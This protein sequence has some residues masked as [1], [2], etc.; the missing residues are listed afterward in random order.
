MGRSR[1]KKWSKFIEEAGV[2]VRIYERAGSKAIYREVRLPDG[3]KD[4]KSL[5]T[6][7]RTE[8]EALARELCRELATAHLTGTDLRRPT[9]GQGFSAYF[10]MRTGKAATLS[11]DRLRYAETCRDLFEAAWGPDL[12]IANLSQTH[13]DRYSASR[14][15][16]ELSPLGKG[17]G[18]GDR[19]PMEVRDG[20]LDNNFRWL[21]AVFN[22]ARRHKVNGKRLLSEN[23]LHDV[24]WPREKNPRRPVASH[25]RFL[26]TMQHV[27]AVDSEG[28]LRAILALARWTGRRESAICGLLASDILLSPERIR[29]ALAA[30]G[31][32]EGLGQHMP[33][34]A[35]RWPATTDKQGILH[36]TPISGAVRNELDRYLK[37]N[38]RMGDTPLFPALGDPEAPIR[39][40]TAS[41]LLLKAEK[42]AE[43]PKLRGGTFHPY[44]R[45]WATERKHLPDADVAAAGGWTDTRALKLSY[46][47]ADAATVLKVV[48]HEVA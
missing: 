12:E 45:L 31:M 2:R 43:L 24:T 42:L 16:G 27:D 29:D 38:P 13:I 18:Q 20:T 19:P 25:Q 41:S 10:D 33:H 8:A 40:D 6:R 44:R 35:I 5:K 34:G 3:S 47:H 14:R 11:E 9:L 28:R 46:Q 39:R 26:A 36:I 1:R 7:D 30:A 32:D 22:W 48:E 21:S 17:T 15:S 4:R 23:P 37:R